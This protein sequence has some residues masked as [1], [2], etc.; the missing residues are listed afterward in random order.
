MLAANVRAR[1]FYARRGWHLDLGSGGTRQ[2]HVAGVLVEE[3]RYRRA[4]S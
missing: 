2:D 4:L 1:A 3:V